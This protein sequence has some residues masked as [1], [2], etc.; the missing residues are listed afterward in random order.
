M[1]AHEAASRQGESISSKLD[2]L[3]E[4]EKSIKSRLEDFD[5]KYR[6]KSRERAEDL[7]DEV[8]RFGE[9]AAGSEEQELQQMFSKHKKDAFS[10]ASRSTEKQREFGKYP[11]Y[12]EPGITAYSRTRSRH[13]PAP[14]TQP[15]PDQ[16]HE[17]PEPS[18]Q[19]TKQPDQSEPLEKTSRH[20]STFNSPTGEHLLPRVVNL[21]ISSLAK[22]LETIAGP[23]MYPHL[24]QTSCFDPYPIAWRHRQPE[25]PLTTRLGQPLR[26][27]AATTQRTG[28]PV[29]HATGRRRAPSALPH[30]PDAARNPGDAADSRP[31][32]HW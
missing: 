5:R 7:R 17:E 20:F 10:S 12:L 32:D 24:T 6:R 3:V 14:Q 26:F 2:K 18:P 31:A 4:S 23:Q 28:R 19:S 21:R 9:S 1:S 16:R 8:L 27:E 30:N 29:H 25:A 15:Q 13:Q 22:T 11:N